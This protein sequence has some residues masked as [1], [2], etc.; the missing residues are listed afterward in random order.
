MGMGRPEGSQS[1]GPI[2]NRV[3][4]PGEI[5]SQ[6]SPRELVLLVVQTVRFHS[7]CVTRSS[8][9]PFQIGCIYPYLQLR[10]PRL[11]RLSKVTEPERRKARALRFLFWR[12]GR[13]QRW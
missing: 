8:Q 3:H 4:I 9:Q 13:E 7:H 11:Y 10:G 12:G 5:Q 1:W 6:L 2:E